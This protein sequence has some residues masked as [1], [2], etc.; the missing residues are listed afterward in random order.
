MDIGILTKERIEEK[1]EEIVAK[2]SLDSQTEH[3][4]CMRYGIGFEQPLTIQE[5]AKR[6][7]KP[8]KKV[9]QQLETVERKVFNLLKDVV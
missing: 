2:A 7:K 4:I 6:I 1:L 9:K 8:V 5:I 3:L